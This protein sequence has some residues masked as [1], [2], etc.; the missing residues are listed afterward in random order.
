MAEEVDTIAIPIRCHCG[1]YVSTSYNAYDGRPSPPSTRCY[2]CL[3]KEHDVER[4]LQDSDATID[5]MVDEA[6]RFASADPDWK[7]MLNDLIDAK[8][9]LT[10]VRMRRKVLS[11]PTYKDPAR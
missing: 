5:R 7:A 6:M 11:W 3:E 9:K 4:R 2:S 10:A 1:N 8:I